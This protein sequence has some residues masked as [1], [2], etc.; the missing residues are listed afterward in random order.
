MSSLEASY[1]QLGDLEIRLLPRAI[2]QLPGWQIAARCI[3][4]ACPGGDYHDFFTLPDGRTAIVI[5]DCSGRG[6]MAVVMLAVVRALLHC[7]PL[8]SGTDAAPFCTL[9]GSMPQPPHCVLGQLNRNVME[10]LPVV[11]LMTMFYGL[12]NPADGTLCYSNAGHPS[13]RLWRAQTGIVGTVG[14]IAG[15]PIGLKLRADYRPEAIQI[16]PNDIFVAFSRGLTEARNEKGEQFGVHR[17]DRGILKSS[18]GNAEAVR[19]SILDS[20]A[21]FLEEQKP[22]E[23]VTLVVVRRA[24]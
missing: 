12:L 23:D 13:P 10:S 4:G 1:H 2:P 6:T 8:S 3:V 11:E 24:S 22:R 9:S 18:D 7:C 19:S 15:T 21:E 14:S 17:I 20:L 16:E 5:G